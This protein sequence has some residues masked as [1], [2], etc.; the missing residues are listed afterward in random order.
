MPGGRP[1]DYNDEILAKAK[2]YLETFDKGKDKDVIPTVEGLSLYLDIARSTIYLWAKDEQKQEF[3]DT[4]KDLEIKQKK[5]LLNKGLTGEFN[6]NITKLV[7]GTH[8]ISEKIHN[9]MS[10]PGG[11]PIQTTTSINFIPVSSKK[12]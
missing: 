10:A 4:L 9:E 11:G 2:E 5:I 1:T 7:L 3:I 6:S 8:G 12:E